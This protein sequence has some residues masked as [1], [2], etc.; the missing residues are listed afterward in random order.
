VYSTLNLIL[1]QNQ[2][3]IPKI[4]LF[5]LM[6]RYFLLLVM[7][8][9]LL[10]SCE[11]E[12]V[13]QQAKIGTLAQSS[14]DTTNTSNRVTQAVGKIATG[15]TIYVPIYPKIYHLENQTLDLT[16]T[17]SIRNTD[18]ENPIILTSVRYYDSN[19]K[20]VKQYID[21][22]KRL[23]PLASIDFLATTQQA[24]GI[25]SSFIVEW[26]ALKNVNPPILE[27]VMLS[28]VST[29]GISFTSVGRVIQNSN[30]VS[31]KLCQ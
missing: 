6:K 30:P 24:K 1:W 26:V 9:I 21:C 19:G 25:G 22:A 5:F 7:V 11:T 15:E 20:L 13:R 14:N 8:F 18:L 3:I 23:D 4:E 27:G 10:T 2:V 29:Q 31:V 28:T 16:T 12:S 17:L